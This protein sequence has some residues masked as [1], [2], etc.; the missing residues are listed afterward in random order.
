LAIF[1]LGKLAVTV[2]TAKS[3]SQQQDLTAVVGH[4]IL[5]DLTMILGSA[6]TLERRDLGPDERSLLIDMIDRHAGRLRESSTLLTDFA[7]DALAPLAIAIVCAADLTADAFRR[8]DER[9]RANV[10]PVLSLLLDQCVDIL[11]GLLQSSPE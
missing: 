5:D 7:D 11:R 6:K 10:V 1:P 3:G 4:R 2:E 9:N 8:D